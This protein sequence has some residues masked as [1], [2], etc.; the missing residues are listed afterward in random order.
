M[1][2]ELLKFNYNFPKTYNSYLLFLLFKEFREYCKEH[3]YI[4]HTKK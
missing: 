1:C 4:L 3:K 2:L